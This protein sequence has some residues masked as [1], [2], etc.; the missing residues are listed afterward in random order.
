M[1]PQ[2]SLDQGPTKDQR[3][4]MQDNSWRCWTQQVANEETD[5]NFSITPSEMLT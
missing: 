4:D 2:F 5:R 3:P 1:I